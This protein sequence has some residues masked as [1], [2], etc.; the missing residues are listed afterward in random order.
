MTLHPPISLEFPS[1]SQTGLCRIGPVGWIT[2]C[3]Q[4]VYASL[5]LGI[6]SNEQ[7]SEEIY[8]GM[9]DG[10]FPVCWID[11]MSASKKNLDGKSL[12]DDLEGYPSHSNEYQSEISLPADGVSNRARP[13]VVERSHVPTR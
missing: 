5:R 8:L 7:Y 11:F 2:Q 6:L 3:L 10:T 12:K 4:Q 13:P 9:R 1:Q